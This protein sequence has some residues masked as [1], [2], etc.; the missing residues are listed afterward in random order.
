MPRPLAAVRRVKSPCRVGSCGLKLVNAHLQR[1]LLLL[2]QSRHALAEGEVRQALGQDPN[3]AFAHAVLALTLV[4][5]EKRADATAAARQAIHLAPDVPFVHYAL[6]RVLYDRNDHAGALKAA[7]EAV[8]LDPADADYLS[9]VAAIHVDERRWP[10]ALEAAERGLQQ[11]AEHVGCTN[12]RA[13]ALVRLGR[14]AEAGATMDA[15]LAKAPED[16]TTHANMGWTLLHRGEPKPAL[17][18]FREALRLDP[19]NEWARAGIVEAL[20]AQNFIYALMLKYFLWMAKFPPGTQWAIILGGYFGF[21]LTAGLAAANPG[22]AVVLL[23]LKFAYIVFALMTWL[24]QPL[25]NLL[26]RLNRFGRLALSREQIVASNWVGACLGLAVVCVVGWLLAGL[27]GP[28]IMGALVF[29]MLALPVSAVFNCAAGWPRRVM[30]GYS[31]LL[32]AV[33]LVAFG[34]ELM[35]AGQARGEPNGLRELAG[36]AFGLFVLGIF[37]NNFVANYLLSRRPQL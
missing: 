25:F 22:L 8:R 29:G 35:T 9:L 23:P 10:A 11:D 20:K 5:Q 1:A 14:K 18:H 28:L 3:D 7:E 33:G 37:L 2:D 6:A 4:G 26:L 24:A 19:E 16:A 13:I 32:A 15:A 17:E 21:R 12:L 31:G 30:A 36:A 34:G 27:T